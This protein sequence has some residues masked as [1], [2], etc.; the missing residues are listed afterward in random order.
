MKMLMA[1]T[2]KPIIL[3]QFVHLAKI[4]V[5]APRQPKALKWREA[6]DKDWVFDNNLDHSR[7]TR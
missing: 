6:R 3:T 5:A 2:K 4:C 7:H 1:S